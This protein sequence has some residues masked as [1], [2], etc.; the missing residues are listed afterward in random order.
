MRVVAA[1]MLEGSRVLACRRATNKSFPGKWE[2]PGGKIEEFESPEVALR[3]ELQ[4]ELGVDA[5]V[6]ELLRVDESSVED[7][8]IELY[9]FRVELRGH[10]PEWSTDHDDMRWIELKKITSLDW[11]IPDLPMVRELKAR[12]S[13]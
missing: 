2:F 7:L 1:V 4:E 6:R 3:R 13:R 10:R 5:V 11:A 12:A 9:C 8:T